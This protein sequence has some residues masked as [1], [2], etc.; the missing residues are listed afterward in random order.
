MSALPC[1]LCVCVCFVL[2]ILFSLFLLLLF[3]LCACSAL[4]FSR[5]GAIWL[6]MALESWWL[7]IQL[8][9]FVPDTCAMKTGNVFF[10]KKHTY[11]KAFAFTQHTP[12]SHPNGQP[13][14]Q[15][16]RACPTFCLISRLFDLSRL[17]LTLR[18]QTQQNTTFPPPQNN[19]EER[20]TCLQLK[21]A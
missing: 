9:Q 10:A 6:F 18:T 16:A 3:F 13:C 8:D 1:L 20:R 17:F 5:A 2:V 14:L 19:G 7:K 11:R 4:W 15:N 12:C 21:L